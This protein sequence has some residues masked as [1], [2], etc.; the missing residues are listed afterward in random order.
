VEQ[1]L[2]RLV[3]GAKPVPPKS[4]PIEIPIIPRMPL[5]PLVYGAAPAGGFGT[6]SANR[7]ESRTNACWG[8]M[9]SL[10]GDGAAS[11][12]A[13]SVAMIDAI[14]AGPGGRPLVE[15]SFG[16]SPWG[17]WAPGSQVA[18]QGLLAVPPGPGI[19]LFYIALRAS[20]LDIRKP[21]GAPDLRYTLLGRDIRLG[22]LA[23]GSAARLRM[24]RASQRNDHRANVVVQEV[25]APLLPARKK[26]RLTPAD[27][28][29][30]A[31]RSRCEPEE[32]F[33]ESI[34][35]AVEYMQEFYPGEWYLK[36]ARQKLIA[37][38][39]ETWDAERPRFQGYDP[40]PLQWVLTFWQKRLLFVLATETA[41][42]DQGG[43]GVWQ[44]QID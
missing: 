40:P 22:T 39:R 34:R 21:T 29:V 6:I 44:R 19:F 33:E 43:A 28:M 36:G 30:A 24:V 17:D 23:Q 16:W 1:K 26:V 32:T 38:A 12:D 35:V 37:M 31:F 9:Q 7:C 10:P 14:E 4:A 41:A 20:T 15:V 2:V 18:M 42:L 27:E 8:F 11:V 3:T 25:E 13:L 5:P